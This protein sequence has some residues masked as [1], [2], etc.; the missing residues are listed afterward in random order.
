MTAYTSKQL[1]D[2]LGVS[3]MTISRRAAN[4]KWPFSKRP[5]RG[6]GKVFNLSDLPAN[7][8]AAIAAYEAR[9]TPQTPS[10]ISDK[11][12]PEKAKAIGLAKMELL[13]AWKTARSNTKPKSKADEQF[14]TAYNSGHCFP[15]LYEILGKINKDKLYRWERQLKASD[16]DYRALCDYRGWSQ[17]T[18]VRGN[19]GPEAEKILLDTYLQ[20]T[21]PSVALAWRATCAILKSRGL[22]CP[23]ERTTRRFIARYTK[24]NYDVVVLMREGEKALDDLVGPYITRDSSLLEVGDVLVADGHRLNFDCIHPFTGKPARMTLILWLDWASRM[25]AGWEIMPEEDTVAISSA[26]YMAIKNLGKIPKVVYLDNGRA[27]RSKYFQN[28]TDDQIPMETRG[29]Y[30]RLNIGVQ[31]SRPY[32]ARS[33]IVERYFSTFDAQC[34]RLLPT[35]RGSS[36][37]DKPAYLARNEKFHRE[38]HAGAV[39]PTIAQATEI[40]QAYFGWYGQQPH[41]GINGRLP[42]E[43]FAEGRGPGVDEQQLVYDFLW[44]KEVRPRRCRVRF[45]GIDY[46]SDALYGINEPVIAMYAWAD[47]SEIHLYTKRGLPLG[48]AKPVEALHPVAR[49]LGDDLDLR[50]I[51]EANKRQRKLKKDTFQIVRDAGG[52]DEALAALPHVSMAREMVPL[53]AVPKAKETPQEPAQIT[54]EERREIEAVQTEYENLK[55]L[56][57]PYERPEF[58]SPL[59]RYEHLFNLVNFEGIDLISEDEDFM[60]RYESSNEFRIVGRRFEQLHKLAAMQAEMAQNERS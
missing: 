34:A 52:D 26:L 27:F 46:E 25:P 58:R 20:P 51:Q 12:I 36:I 15:S 14:F 59:E 10:P 24:E 9:Q 38:R 3:V 31:Y 11:P 23:A 53:R 33:K 56:A 45:A 1:A 55:K 21:R 18:G 17:A 5:G 29:L 47:M 30:T 7:I 60:R 40:I 43:V 44:R 48:P 19:V 49:Q 37:A 8:G 57:P 54:D 16:G 35:Y 22:E 28:T 41:E 2:V 39:V 42:L 13:A 50:K 4:E 32:H 6:G